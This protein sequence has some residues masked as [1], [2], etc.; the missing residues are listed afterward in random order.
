M[1]EM[2]IIQRV[3]KYKKIIILI[4]VFG[5]VVLL[6]DAQH[7]RY[8]ELK[9]QA[10]AIH[11]GYN[12]SDTLHIP[13]NT[14]AVRI[15]SPYSTKQITDR[16]RVYSP[17]NIQFHLEDYSEASHLKSIMTA[18][19]LT[20]YKADHPGTS[21]EGVS[22]ADILNLEGGTKDASPHIIMQN[23]KYSSKQTF[24][25][26][27]E[28]KELNFWSLI[29]GKVHKTL[30]YIADVPYQNNEIN[31]DESLINR[32]I[33]N[34]IHGALVQ[35]MAQGQEEQNKACPY[36]SFHALKKEADNDLYSVERVN[37]SYF[38]HFRPED[39]KYNLGFEGELIMVDIYAPN[40]EDGEKAFLTALAQDGFKPSDKLRVEYIHKPSN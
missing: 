1:V 40:I 10:D 7:A 11:A 38:D 28:S 29:Y 39:A 4:V 33:S 6:L 2:R 19:A 16:Y 14:T 23:G 30:T 18:D 26:I 27:F 35:D 31:Q 8:A 17:E 20:K 5:V 12:E 21:F 22:D 34:K 9:Y 25:I 24:H 15:V 13:I 3:S 32:Y 37:C 36:W